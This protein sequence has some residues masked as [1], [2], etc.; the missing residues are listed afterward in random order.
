MKFCEECGAQL[1][2][3]AVFCEECGAQVDDT[4]LP[5]PVVPEK[6]QKKSKLP[7]IIG[8]IGGAVLIAVIVIV[9][10]VVLKKGKDEIPL[11][12]SDATTLAAEVDTTEPSKENVTETPTTEAPTETPPTQEPTTEVDILF[13]Q[14]VR[15]DKKYRFVYMGSISDENEKMEIYKAEYNRWLSGVDYPG[16]FVDENGRLGYEFFFGYPYGVY[17]F[18]GRGTNGGF[19]FFLF[20][21]ESTYVAVFTQ[22]T[23]G[24]RKEYVTTFTDVVDVNKENLIKIPINDGYYSEV[25]V[26]IKLNDDIYNSQCEIKANFTLSDRTIV[27]YVHKTIPLT[28]IYARTYTNYSDYLAFFDTL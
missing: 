9:V 23:N 4:P 7:I 16:I 10:V 1:E 12:N 20:K 11:V 8:A 17:W 28:D 15:L 18:E 27:N 19:L 5:T 2:D 25:V 6:K 22:I 13:E 26:S 14:F 21:R 24:S 3:D